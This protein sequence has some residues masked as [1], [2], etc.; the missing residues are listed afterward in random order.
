[1]KKLMLLL[2]LVLCVTLCGCPA[3][4]ENTAKTNLQVHITAGKIEPGMTADDVL[5]EVTIDHQPVACRVELTAL[6]EDGYYTMAQ[7][8]PV[9]A[10]NLI[11]LDVYYSLPKGRTVDDIDVTMTCDGGEYDGTG[12]VGDD[13]TGCV[14]A[15]SHAIYGEEPAPQPA[16]HSVSIRVWKLEP[17]MTAEQIEL[18]VSV[19]G[20]FVEH[21]VEMTHH[22]DDGMRTLEKTEKIPDKALVRLNVYYWLPQ[23][24]NL[25]NIEVSMTFPDGDYAGTG[26]IRESDDGLIEAWSHAF[27]DT[28]PQDQEQE[29][30]QTQKPHTHSWQEK[31][32]YSITSCTS[33]STKTYTCAC[34]QTKTETIP[35][36]GH[37]MIEDSNIK[38]T[39]TQEGSITQHCKR[40]GAGT[41]QT[42]PATGHTWSAW[43]QE[44]GRIHIRTCSVCNAEEEANHKIPAGSVTCTD[45]GADIIN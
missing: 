18:D 41:I 13:D 4:T 29:Q 25:D 17:G 11:R 26:S 1:M 43:E 44:N 9:S 14:E 8:E 31:P 22:T 45:C 15:W 24:V 40:C 35:A 30:E 39:C 36:P 37:D 16:V 6:T 12:S 33:D 28:R 3:Q 20:M 34:G 5:V 38:P 10:E 2:V 42:I 21:R 7:D 23:G 27:Y 32:G 19:D